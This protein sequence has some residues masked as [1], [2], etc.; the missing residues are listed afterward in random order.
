MSGPIL[1]ERIEILDTLDGVRVMELRE[2]LGRGG[3]IGT[4]RITESDASTESEGRRNDVSNDVSTPSWSA[5][6][7]IEGEG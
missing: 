1:E 7:C 4:R 2:G 3:V 6:E 5:I